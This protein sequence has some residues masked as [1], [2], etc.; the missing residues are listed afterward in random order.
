MKGLSIEEINKFKENTNLVIMSENCEL[1][2]AEGETNDIFK[3]DFKYDL[4]SPLSLFCNN[5]YQNLTS[6]LYYNS[7]SRELLFGDVKIGLNS[8]EYFVIDLLQNLVIVKINKF[9]SDLINPIMETTTYPLFKYSV[10]SEYN[11]LIKGEVCVKFDETQLEDFKLAIIRDIEYSKVE[12]M[13]KYTVELF[14]QHIEKL[15][16]V[17]ES[18]KSFLLYNS[19]IYR[20]VSIDNG[21]IVLD[22]IEDE[23]YNQLSSI[24]LS[25]VELISNNYS[26]INKYEYTISEGILYYN[27]QSIQY[28]FNDI[29]RKSYNNSKFQTL[30]SVCSLLIDYLQM[31][32]MMDVIIDELYTNYK[33]LAEEIL[34]S[35][36]HNIQYM[37]EHGI[38]YV[39]KG[40]IIFFNKDIINGSLIQFK[41]LIEERKQITNL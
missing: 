24:Q 17:I 30:N 6:D 40:D 9:S 2:K 8:D 39:H 37:L 27:G 5:I 22:C 36:K 23:K 12:A 29:V 4:K 15:E 33:T 16:K 10:T 38:G 19:R 20:I 28:T 31:E 41:N 7:S 25:L 14:K 26:I 32:N 18:E 21:H 35:E 3:L 1:I 13:T 11:G 34:S